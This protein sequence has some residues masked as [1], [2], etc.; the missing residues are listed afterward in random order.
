MTKSI[1]SKI[2]QN[3]MI[4]IFSIKSFI[5]NIDGIFSLMKIITISKT[6]TI[7]GFIS[8]VHLVCDSESE[9]YIKRVY[10]EMS[11]L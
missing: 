10:C 1:S 6:L 5:D 3:P 4:R 9:L 11:M 7:S 2:Y 8:D